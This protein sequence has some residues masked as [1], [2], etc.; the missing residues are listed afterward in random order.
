MAITHVVFTTILIAGRKPLNEH[1]LVAAYVLLKRCETREVPQSRTPITIYM[2]RN[3]GVGLAE[4]IGLRD[5]A[6][7]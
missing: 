6:R 7:Y 5:D 4:R 2:C 3:R 1:G